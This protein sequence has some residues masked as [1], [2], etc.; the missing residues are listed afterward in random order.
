NSGSVVPTYNDILIQLVAR[1][2]AEHELL[3]AAWVNECVYLYDV[4]NIGL[5]VETESG[6]LAP[7]LRE[8]NHLSLS[9]IVEQS[10]ALIQRAR[11]GKLNQSQLDGATFTVSNLGMLGVDH[12]TPVLNLPQSAILGIGRL[13][14]EPVVRNGQIV[15]G[16]TLS[17]SLTFDHRILDGAPAARWLQRL[18]QLIETLDEEV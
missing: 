5:A 14:E 3:N 7:V 16:H 4:I 11:A 8:V 12:F 18:C 6:L 9:E 10:Q 1:S 17:L 13:V 2:L 15:I